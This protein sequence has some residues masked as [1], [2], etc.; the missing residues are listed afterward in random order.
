MLRPE[1]RRCRR[2]RRWLTSV[3]L[4]PEHPDA[5]K[6]VQPRRG[7]IRT[8][9]LHLLWPW[10]CHLCGQDDPLAGGRPICASCTASL[11]EDLLTSYCTRCGR[12]LADPVVATELCPSCQN[13]PGHLD[14][15]AIACRYRR[16]V[17]QCIVQWK[18]SQCFG[19][20]PQLVELLSD[21]MACQPW[22]RQVEALVPIPQ[23]WTRWLKRRMI[24]P[25]RQLAEGLS[26]NTGH[27]VWPLLRARPHQQQVGLSRTRRLE[28]IRG[29]FRVAAGMD[30]TGKRLCLVDDVTTTGATLQNAAR[31]LRKAGAAQVWGIVV[32]KSLGTPRHSTGR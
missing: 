12:E 6:P 3:R 14:G 16:L 4:A 24:W 1:M 9:G 8:A 5:E 10:R 29:V 27:P 21:A 32:A 7:L 18:F 23:P 13:H 28:N 17:R 15:L 11:H 26:R 19:L 2:L 22:H 31:I 30:L 25:V 20:E